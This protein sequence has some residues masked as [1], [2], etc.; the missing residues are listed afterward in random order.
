MNYTIKENGDIFNNKGKKL[1]THKNK[2]GYLLCYL[3]NGEGKKETLLHHRVIAE[4]FI[5]NPKNKPFVNHINGDKTDNRVKNL[6]WVTAKENSY[7]SI[8]TLNKKM[9]GGDQPKLNFF[10]AELIRHFYRL[11]KNITQLSKEYGVSRTSINKIINHES[12]K[13]EKY[14]KTV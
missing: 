12:Y 3:Y 9:K 5:S 8:N 6:E 13:Y 7:H 14:L 1:K 11:G 2:E 10:K 4:K